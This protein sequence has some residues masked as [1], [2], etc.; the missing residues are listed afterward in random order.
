MSTAQTIIH[1]YGPKATSTILTLPISL[2]SVD[3][4]QLDSNMKYQNCKVRV[5]FSEHALLFAICYFI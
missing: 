4:E 1:S 2:L 5:E 3:T